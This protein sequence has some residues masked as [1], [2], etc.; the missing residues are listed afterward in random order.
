MKSTNHL[1]TVL[2]AAC[3]AGAAAYSAAEKKEV[4][5]WITVEKGFPELAARANSVRA[6]QRGRA[7]APHNRA[8]GRAS[9]GSVARRSLRPGPAA[10]R[11]AVEGS[12]R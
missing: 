11:D 7:D 10:I 12:P 8:R 1:F 5:E 4:L 9:R 2:L 3:S 6:P